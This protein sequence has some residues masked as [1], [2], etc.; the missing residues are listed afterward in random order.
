MPTRQQF[1]TKTDTP[2]EFSEWRKMPTPESANRMLRAIQPSIDKGIQAHVGSDAGPTIQGHAKRILLQSLQRYDPAESKLSTFVIN[3]LQG[4]RRV[5]R[6]QQQIIR[7]PERVSLDQ[8]HLSSAENDLRDRYGRDPTTEEL[9]D[10]T[11]L[12]VARI[13]RVRQYKPP[14]SEGYFIER[15][16][17][18]SGAGHS[19]TIASSDQPWLEAVYS[20]LP[21]QDKLILEH[22]LGMYGHRP[23]STQQIA[24]KLKLSP[25]AISQ[26]RAKIQ[27]MLDQQEQ[28][29]LFQ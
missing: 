15:D 29:G 5:S 9:A 24:T 27:A 6:E 11:G 10:S 4:L 13:A 23:L 2:A 25:G 1:S 12:S 17:S 20:S 19:P 18:G 3:S 26:R 14:V 21:D 7:T 28:L 8:A 22:S 16:E